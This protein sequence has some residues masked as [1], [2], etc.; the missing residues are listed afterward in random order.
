MEFLAS[1]EIQGDFFEISYDRDFIIYI[2]NKN[3][4]FLNIH[5]F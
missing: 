4:L 1:L 3:T 2:I 5:Y